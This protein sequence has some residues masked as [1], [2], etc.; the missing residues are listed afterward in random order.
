[1]YKSD[2]YNRAK[3]IIDNRRSEAR[4]QS[5]RRTMELELL[6]PELRRIGEELRK[7]GPTILKT[8]CEGG[9]IAPIKERNL[10]LNEERKAIIKALGYPEDYTEVK[11]TCSKCQDSGY[12]DIKMCSCLKEL[13]FTEGIKSSGI[14]RLIEEQSFDNFDISVYDDAEVRSNMEKV[15]DKARKFADGFDGKYRGRN[16]LFIG[17]TGTGKTHISTS[18]ARAV[19]AKGYGVIYDSAQN[20]INDFENDKFHSGYGKQENSSDKYL[21]CDLLIIDDLGTEFSTP[22]SVS[23]LYNIFTTRRNR[24]LSTIVSTN[25]SAE[26][27]TKKYDDRIYSRIVGSDYK[28]YF[29]QGNDYRLRKRK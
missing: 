14:G 21:D 7:I 28:V 23:C 18:I 24:G 11:Y 29:F 5:N 17:K 10:R 4:N 19:I 6:S 2:N 27:I 12:I 20:I 15:L 16:L 22:F 9:D 26:E 8:A 1:M 3:E 13:L 25:L